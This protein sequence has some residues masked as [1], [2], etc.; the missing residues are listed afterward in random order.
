[1]SSDGAPSR[2][3]FAGSQRRLQDGPCL[4]DNCNMQKIALQKRNRGSLHPL[5]AL[6][7]SCLLFA[8]ATA[9]YA[10]RRLVLIDEDGSGPGGTNQMAILALLQSP[11]VQVLGITMVTGD[12]FPLCHQSEESSFSLYCSQ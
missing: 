5:T 12:G 11:H 6:V 2:L 7:T 8:L 10:Q 9:C 1:M 3:R 4:S